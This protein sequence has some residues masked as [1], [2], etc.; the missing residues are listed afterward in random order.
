VVRPGTPEWHPNDVTVARP[1]M[2]ERRR[3]I[4]RTVGVLTLILRLLPD[5]PQ[6]VRIA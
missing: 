2:I 5:T 6:M 1:M 3:S 4:L